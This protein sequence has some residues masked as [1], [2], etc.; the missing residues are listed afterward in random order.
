MSECGLRS[1]A[2]TEQ[3]CS[4]VECISAMYSMCVACVCSTHAQLCTHTYTC[5]CTHTCIH[6]HMH[7]DNDI[8]AKICLY[9]CVLL[10]VDLSMSFPLQTCI[11]LL[12]LF[13]LYAHQPYFSP[14]NLP[15]PSCSPSVTVGVAV[16]V[17]SGVLLLI[18]VNSACLGVLV[19]RDANKQKTTYSLR[20]SVSSTLKFN[21]PSLY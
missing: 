9:Y 20:L 16:T 7:T 6:S 17:V 10:S 11:P 5:M 18:A 13:H 4:Y 3:R 15:H 14:I 1:T 19:T 12:S 2:T 8:C 21:Q